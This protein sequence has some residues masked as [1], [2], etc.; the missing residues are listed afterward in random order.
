LGQL[1]RTSLDPTQF[2]T[3]LSLMARL[4]FLFFHLCFFTTSVL[5][6]QE[7]KSS[8]EDDGS[9]SAFDNLWES[10]DR[11]LYAL[12]VFVIMGYFLWRAQ[13]LDKDD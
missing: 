6:G 5:F 7:S 1:Q 10:Y 13:R 9:G 11:Y 3:T 8:A 2:I 12:I 4:R